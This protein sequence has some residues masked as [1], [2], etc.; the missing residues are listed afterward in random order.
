MSEKNNIALGY[1]AINDE[2][3]SLKGGGNYGKFGL[4]VYSKGKII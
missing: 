3:A 2:D 1:G 4:K